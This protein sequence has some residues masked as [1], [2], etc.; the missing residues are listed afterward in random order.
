M[1]VLL[2]AAV[3]AVGEAGEQRKAW[4]DEGAAVCQVEDGLTSPR[5]KNSNETEG[6]HTNG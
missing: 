5:R 4:M 6:P 3:R 1:I 2:Y